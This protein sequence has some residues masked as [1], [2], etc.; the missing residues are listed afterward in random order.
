M[1]LSMGIELNI[2]KR[3]DFVRSII[4]ILSILRLERRVSFIDLGH[5]IDAFMIGVVDLF[6]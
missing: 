1:L 3:Y 4:S 2:F 6:F 5:E